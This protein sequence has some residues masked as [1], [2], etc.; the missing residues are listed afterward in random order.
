MNPSH[1]VQRKKNP[2]KLHAPTV[3]CFGALRYPIGSILL[4]ANFLS[5]SLPSDVV[6]AFFVD[7]ATHNLLHLTISATNFF[8]SN[9]TVSAESI[10]VASI[11]PFFFLPFR[12]ITSGLEWNLHN[13]HCSERNR[14]VCRCGFGKPAGIA[15]VSNIYFIYI[16]AVSSPRIYIQPGGKES[17]ALKYGV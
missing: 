5:S 1:Q 4:P 3:T 15:E 2:I 13:G 6:T 11:L 16:A 7:S 10:R 8:A 14:F 12:Q 9:P 17:A